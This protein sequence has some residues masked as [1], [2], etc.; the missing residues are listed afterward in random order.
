MLIIQFPEPV[1]PRGM[2]NARRFQAPVREEWQADG[3]WTGLFDIAAD[4]RDDFLDVVE[5]A[6]D[7]TVR[8]REIDSEDDIVNH[9]MAFLF[10]SEQLEEA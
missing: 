1:A 3:T 4:R 2:A 6:S 8:V 10:T 5:E 7:G 9:R